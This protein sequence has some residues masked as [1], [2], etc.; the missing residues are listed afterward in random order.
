MMISKCVLTEKE[1]NP[2][3]RLDS[4]ASRLKSKP[5][6]YRENSVETMSMTMRALR[7]GQMSIKS[8]SC[9]AVSQLPVFARHHTPYN[10]ASPAKPASLW[11]G[12][13]NC[14]SFFCPITYRRFH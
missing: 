7:V 13:W 5:H 6:I 4:R 9:Y 8:A 10:Y 11:A 2:R 12:L 14:S 3:N 1:V